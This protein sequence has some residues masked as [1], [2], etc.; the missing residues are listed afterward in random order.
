M[1]KI[2]VKNID[3]GKTVRE[4]VS[5]AL[6]NADVFLFR[7]NIVPKQ[8]LIRFQRYVFGILDVDAGI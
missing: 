1:D 3:L 5:I 7:Q 8:V 4:S 6:S 2:Y